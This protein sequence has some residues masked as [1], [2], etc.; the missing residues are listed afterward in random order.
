[1]RLQFILTAFLRT[2]MVANIVV[3]IPFTGVSG[4]PSLMTSTVL[5]I[6]GLPVILIMLSITFDTGVFVPPDGF[7][8][9]RDN[10][11]SAV[12]MAD[13]MEESGFMMLCVD[14]LNLP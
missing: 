8:P 5:G 11:I 7:C 3:T 10:E 6:M 2:S 1:M 14:F 13:K 4:E 12:N 9:A